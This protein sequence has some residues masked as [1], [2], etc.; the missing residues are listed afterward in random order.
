MQVRIQTPPVGPCAGFRVVD[1]ST[2]VSGPMCT[3]NLA[4]PQVA[5]NRTVVA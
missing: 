5:A 1:L 2:V 3:M 4:D